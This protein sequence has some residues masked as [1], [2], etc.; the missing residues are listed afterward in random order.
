MK[1]IR[2]VFH[3]IAARAVRSG[4]R[5][6][7]L[8]ASTAL[9]AAVLAAAFLMTGCQ[10]LSL[11]SGEGKVERTAGEPLFGFGRRADERQVADL[12]A[13]HERLGEQSPEQLDNEIAELRDRVGGESDTVCTETRL[14]LG[15]VGLV[16]HGAIEPSL[17]GPCLEVGTP[18]AVLRFARLLHLELMQLE[19]YTVSVTALERRVQTQRQEIA[20]LKRQLEGLKA[21]E[22]S[23]QRRDQ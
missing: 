13:F 9:F 3:S 2:I 8:S 6:A 22:R 7:S 4:V 1:T 10:T 16:R 23:L 11:P 14:Q 21:I 20:E 5:R 17:I 15:V 19:Q 12:L 18:T